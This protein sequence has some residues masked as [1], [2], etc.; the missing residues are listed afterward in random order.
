[1]IHEEIGSDFR[2]EHID[3]NQGIRTIDVIIHSKVKETKIEFICDKFLE[4]K[5]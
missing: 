4:Q 1:M 3:L 5:I 2:I